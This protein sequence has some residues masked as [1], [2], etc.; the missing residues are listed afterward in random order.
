V[1][2]EGLNKASG[3]VLK[4]PKPADGTDFD[5]QLPNSLFASVDDVMKVMN[6]TSTAQIVEICPED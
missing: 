3:D 6:G 1:K 5:F 4:A 2:A